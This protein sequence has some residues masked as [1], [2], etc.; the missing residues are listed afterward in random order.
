[1]RSDCGPKAAEIAAKVDSVS[2][3]E[4]KPRPLFHSSL[5]PEGSVRRRR[6]TA[7]QPGTVS[8]HLWAPAPV[9]P[10]VSVLENER[11]EPK[12]IVGFDIEDGGENRPYL[13][14]SQSFWLYSQKAGF[15]QCILR[16]LIFELDKLPDLD[17]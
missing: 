4:H 3:S 15:V 13:A 5:P 11:I 2:V 16:T 7:N 6:C 1:M 10:L 8:Y 12:L 17:I 9:K 14:S